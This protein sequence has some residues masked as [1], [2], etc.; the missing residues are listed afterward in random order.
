[1]MFLVVAFTS[2]TP[3]PTLK[4]R[5]YPVKETARTNT[6]L[7]IWLQAAQKDSEAAK[8]TRARVRENVIQSP[9]EHEH[10]FEGT[11]GI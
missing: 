4:E 9:N 5:F 3:K 10:G 6:W 2:A 8:I 11:N 7:K 1:M